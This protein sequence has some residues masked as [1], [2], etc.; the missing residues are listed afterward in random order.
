MPS[1]RGDAGRLVQKLDWK[2]GEQGKG[3]LTETEFLKKDLASR[4]GQARAADTI[5]QCRVGS[6]NADPAWP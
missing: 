6:R 5:P 4:E 1:L 2:F 3:M